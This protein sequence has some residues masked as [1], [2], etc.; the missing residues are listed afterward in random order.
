MNL[1]DQKQKSKRVPVAVFIA[2]G[3]PSVEVNRFKFAIN[4]FFPVLTVDEFKAQK[5]TI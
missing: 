3:Q 4:N 2:S 1:L 5:P